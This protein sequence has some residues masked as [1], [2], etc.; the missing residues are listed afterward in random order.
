MMDCF[1]FFLISEILRLFLKMTCV[2][3]S[4][5]ES[6]MVAVIGTSLNDIHVGLNKKALLV[7]H[8]VCHVLFRDKTRR[9]GNKML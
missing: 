2:M 9:L 1:I 3:S 8:S 4:Q 7:F 6:Q 5:H